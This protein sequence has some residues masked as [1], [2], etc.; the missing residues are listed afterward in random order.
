MYQ[1]IKKRCHV[2]EK[3]EAIA[4]A[5]SCRSSRF[6]D[7]GHKKNNKKWRAKKEERGTSGR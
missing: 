7:G 3:S 5:R 4:C 2:T 1:T 6:K